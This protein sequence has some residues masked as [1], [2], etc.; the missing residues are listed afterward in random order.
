[1][2]R[3]G[4]QCGE[5]QSTRNTASATEHPPFSCTTLRSFDTDVSHLTLSSAE[6]SAQTQGV[7]TL[8]HLLLLAPQ[9][10]LT[11]HTLTFAL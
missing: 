9:H 6:I 5:Q 1:V 10:T 11:P 3:V 2:S 7:P 8:K 4:R